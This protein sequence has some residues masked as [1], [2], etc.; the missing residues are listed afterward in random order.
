VII[1][2]S[3]LVNQVRDETDQADGELY[4]DYCHRT[5]IAA[6]SQYYAQFSPSPRKLHQLAV[7]RLKRMND[8][9]IQEMELDED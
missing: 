1:S 4:L 5:Y 8:K 2:L 7:D 9:G 3:Q 6:E